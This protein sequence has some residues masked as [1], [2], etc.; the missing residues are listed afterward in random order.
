MPE[1]KKKNSRFAHLRK[2]K[3]APGLEVSMRDKRYVA[4]PPIS[5]QRFVQLHKIR[6]GVGM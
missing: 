3:A 4:V 5:F 2:V 6:M 1:D